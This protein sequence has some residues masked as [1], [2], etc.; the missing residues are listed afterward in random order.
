MARL[1]KCCPGW[2]RVVVCG[3]PV[4]SSDPIRVSFVCE[5]FVWCGKKEGCL[6]LV[7]IS[8][9]DKKAFLFDAFKNPQLLKGN[10]SL[11]KILEHDSILKVIHFCKSD[12]YSLHHGFGV[13]LRN[14]FDTSIA[15]N[16]LTEEVNMIT[17]SN[18]VNFCKLVGVGGYVRNRDFWEKMRETPDFWKIRPLPE[19]MIY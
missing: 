8:T 16:T 15:I 10:S 3:A 11:K 18:F 5:V 12:T 2:V 9:W 4:F 19:E 13:T 1:T 17:Y 14:V 7:Q 6:T